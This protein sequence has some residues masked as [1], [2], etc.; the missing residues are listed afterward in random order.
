[1]VES[2][3][4]LPH[5]AVLLP[6]ALLPMQ[7]C[8]PRQKAEPDSLSGAWI[9]AHGEAI[10]SCNHREEG[11]FDLDLSHL[12]NCIPAQRTSNLF[13]QYFVQMFF[14]P[15][16]SKGETFTFCPSSLLPPLYKE[17]SHLLCRELAFKQ[18]LHPPDDPTKLPLSMQVSCFFWV[19]GKMCQF[20]DCLPAYNPF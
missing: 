20:L 5:L 12:I 14:C 1:M 4:G 16:F 10:C 13:L 17:K 9:P 11:F 2:V 8:R 3:W 18:D 7:A 6:E 19:K 15:A